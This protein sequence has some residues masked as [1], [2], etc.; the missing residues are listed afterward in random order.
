MGLNL[1]AVPVVS[2]LPTSRL[3]MKSR[4][5]SPRPRFR[6]SQ[7]RMAAV[8]GV[9]DLEFISGKDG[10]VDLGWVAPNV[11][12]ARFRGA[13]TSSTGHAFATRLN[14]LIAP[15]QSLSLFCDATELKYYDLL[16]RSSF[17]RV[18]H[19]NR[20]KFAKVTVLGQSEGISPQLRS[21]VATL[22]EPVELLTQRS[23][24]EAQLARKAPQSLQ[25]ID[26]KYAALPSHSAPFGR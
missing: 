19:S 2:W 14:L 18:V 17:A 8:S 4:P 6:P 5:T 7:P 10:S 22:G 13:F 20:R 21:L 1:T 9:P 15:V 16:A 23:K 12:Y 24:F 3:S 11:L 25:K 26:S